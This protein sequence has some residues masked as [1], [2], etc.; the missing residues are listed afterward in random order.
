MQIIK[1]L[2]GSIIV[3]EVV[4]KFIPASIKG[5][6]VRPKCFRTFSAVV[7]AEEHVLGSFN[8][9]SMNGSKSTTSGPEED[10]FSRIVLSATNTD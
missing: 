7:V 1:Q 9:N 2:L 6:T 10:I 3:N 4:M 8:H 5:E